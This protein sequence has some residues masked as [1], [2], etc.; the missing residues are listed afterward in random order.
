M[1]LKQF[2]KKNPERLLKV[3]KCILPF[4]SVARIWKP[5]NK[6]NYGSTD[7]VQSTIVETCLILAQNISRFVSCFNFFLLAGYQ[8][9]V[10]EI[11]PL[12]SKG[13][14][15]SEIAECLKRLSEAVCFELES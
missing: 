7:I 2:S 10:R 12:R 14:L 4:R 1:S 13:S 3:G 6:R 9:S 5:T 15:S 11:A 8:S